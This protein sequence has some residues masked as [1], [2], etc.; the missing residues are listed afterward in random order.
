MCR[1]T[2]AVCDMAAGYEPSEAKRLRS[3]RNM[4]HVVG[5][6]PADGKRSENNSIRPKEA[7]PKY[8]DSASYGYIYATKALGNNKFLTFLYI[9]VLQIIGGFEAFYGH[10]IFARDG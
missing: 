10:A 5:G 2:L 1:S 6:R 7:E 3:A 8:F 4:L 9:I